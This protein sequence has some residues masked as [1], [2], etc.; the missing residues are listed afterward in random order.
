M[1]KTTYRKWP[2]AV[3]ESA[4]GLSAQRLLLACHER[5]TFAAHVAGLQEFVLYD[6]DAAFRVWETFD[7]TREFE[8][9]IILVDFRAN[10]TTLTVDYDGSSSYRVANAMLAAVGRHRD[11]QENSVNFWRRRV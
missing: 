4:N 6:S 3:I 5:P 1:F 7:P 8:S 9:S 2:S 11:N 10:G